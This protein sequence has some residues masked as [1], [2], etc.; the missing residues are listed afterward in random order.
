MATR[1]QRAV[2]KVVVQRDSESEESSDEE[3]E[4]DAF[5]EQEEEEEEQEEEFADNASVNEDEEQEDNAAT[6]SSST[7]NGKKKKK[8][9]T[10]S[11]KLAKLCKV[12]KA[13][14]HQAGFVG[15]VY[16]DCPNK[17][18]F[19]CKQPGHTTATC[20]HR[21][22]SEHGV[23]P[24]PRRQSLGMIDFVHERQI[25]SQISK[26]MPPPVIPNRVDCAIIKLHSR[27]VT[28]LEFHPTK[29][30][31][32][33]S[34]DKKGQVGIWDFEK[35]YEKIVYSSIHTCI[36]GSIRFHPTST[37]MIYSCGA[38]G[39]VSCSDLE[40]GLPNRAIDLN[41]D[42]W[43]GPSTW[44]MMY[45]MDINSTRNVV[46]ASDNVGLLHQVDIRTNSRIGKPLLIHKKGS[47]VV[48]LHCNPVDPDLF[49]SSGNDHM[50]R[51]WDM[52]FLDSQGPL[53][54]LPHPRVVNSAFFSPK[55]GNKILTTCQDNRL[56]VYDCIF[57]NLSEPSREIVHSHDFNRYLTCFRAEW[58]PKDPS[59]N[60]A[61]IGRY[62]S[63]DF[64]GIAL[65]PIDFI[66]IST[67]QLVAEVV[68][69]NITTITPVNKLHPRL[70]VLAS[71]S[72]RSLYIW[73]PSDEMEDEDKDLEAE[74]EIK[75][76]VTIFTVPD[77][78]AAKKG[79]EKR[80]F[81]EDDDDDDDMLCNG[82]QGKANVL[83][84][85]DEA[86]EV[87]VAHFDGSSN[88]DCTVL[89]DEQMEHDFCFPLRAGVSSTGNQT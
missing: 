73:R 36:V 41:P 59:E 33:I 44:R 23:T 86:N 34:G 66:D 26:M 22:A 35:V 18:C 87:H 28:Y 51:I 42:G 5:E 71:G 16:V 64:N 63:D 61:V 2:R 45:G 77:H 88:E 24:A 82:K 56:R 6:P 20:P 72:S 60:L 30:N 65:H 48:G 27:R 8:P 31:I 3:M 37:E 69:K 39:T 1:P 43:N 14:D 58:D 46:L 54:E 21:I 70:D 25:R 53:A 10:I 84:L 9:I 62:I 15:S 13:N 47:K 85:E 50:A 83:D 80:K 38:D 76:K 67:G 19:L 57:S 89:K 78:A 32:L 7:Q 55:T 4:N 52:R 17:P 11:L 29:D 79:K 49:I 75:R 68:D 12:C 74:D 40:T 81:D